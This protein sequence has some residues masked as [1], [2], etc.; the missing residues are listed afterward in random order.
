MRTQVPGFGG[1]FGVIEMSDVYALADLMAAMVNANRR[2]DEAALDELKE[3]FAERDQK[4]EERH[5]RVIDGLF[6]Q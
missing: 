1:Y 4:R 3:R 5:Q 2:G 6:G